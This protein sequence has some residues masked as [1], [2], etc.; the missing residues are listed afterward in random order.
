VTEILLKQT[1][2]DR[3]GDVR[4]VI[5]DAYPSP[6]Q[7]ARADPF[8]L[9][10]RIRTLG[11]G[12]QRT[13]QLLSLGH[14]LSKQPIPRQPVHLRALPGIG[15]YSAAAVACFA[16]GQRCIALDV[17]VARIL[18]RLFGLSLERGELRKS[19]M[20]AAI[21]QRLIDGAYPRRINWALLDLGAAVCRPRPKCD[22]CP[23]RARCQYVRASLLEPLT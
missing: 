21:G 14:A 12:R 19:A 1:R 17:N 11:F 23:L 15:P 6:T 5:L 16:Y 8:A 13:E 22:V 4:S 10:K 9:A 3:V 18:S 7:L 20:I 2:A